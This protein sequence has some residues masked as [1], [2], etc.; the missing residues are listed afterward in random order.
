MGKLF[1]QRQFHFVAPVGKTTVARARA[2]HTRE[3]E[4]ERERESDVKLNL[5]VKNDK[6]RLSMKQENRD[7]GRS[8]A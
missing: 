5:K 1:F 2:H 8:I 4:R 7:T 3:R 6:G